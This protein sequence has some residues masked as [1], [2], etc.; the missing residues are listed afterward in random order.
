MNKRMNNVYKITISI[1]AVLILLGI[2]FIRDFKKGKNSAELT[3]AQNLNAHTRGGR[4]VK[5][6]RDRRYARDT[7][8]EDQH[9]SRPGF[10]DRHVG[11]SA[12]GSLNN[13]GGE[14]SGDI[15][16][17]DNIIL[18]EDDVD[19]DIKIDLS[20]VRGQYKDLLGINKSPYVKT[21]DGTKEIDFTNIYK[22]LDFSEIRMHDDEVD[23]CKIYHDDTAIE[24]TTGMDVTESCKFTGKISGIVS[25]N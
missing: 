20:K 24:T 16:K 14:E 9:P 8:G 21:R 22:M 19:I 6:G 23:V 7:V 17:A 2:I 5:N 11:P 3:I 12:R 25:V 4:H 13:S 18:N 10:N 15:K 1:T